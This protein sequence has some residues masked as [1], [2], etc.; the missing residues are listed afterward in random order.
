MPNL[1]SLCQSC[2]RYA[3]SL[4]INQFASCFEVL[5]DHATLDQPRMTSSHGNRLT[6]T[7]HRMGRAMSRLASFTMRLSRRV[8]SDLRI[9]RL[10]VLRKVT[11]NPNIHRGELACL[12]RIL[13]RLC[14]AIESD[15]VQ[16]QPFIFQRVYLGRLCRVAFST[17][18]C[19]RGIAQRTAGRECRRC[20]RRP[21]RCCRQLL[22]LPRSTINLAKGP[23]S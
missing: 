1:T 10:C 22:R 12:C 7:Y 3:C 23:P 17:S 15:D 13:V 16:D 19:A 21:A 4:A 14:F 8:L 9:T 6:L 2:H 11:I 5:S 20:R 18:V